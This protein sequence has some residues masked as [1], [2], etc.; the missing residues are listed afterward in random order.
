MQNIPKRRGK[1]VFL[2][3]FKDPSS[4]RLASGS[5]GPSNDFRVK[6]PTHL[7]EPVTSGVSL[8]S[9]GRAAIAQG[10]HFPINRRAREAEGEVPRFST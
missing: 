1:R 9:L 5:P 3:S 8:S 6:E 7:G 10:A 2:L 4:P